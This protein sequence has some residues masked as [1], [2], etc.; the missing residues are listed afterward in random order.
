M[1]RA[2]IGFAFSFAAVVGAALLLRYGSGCGQQCSKGRCC[3][4]SSNELAGTD[5]VC[6]QWT[7]YRC[8]SP[9]SPDVQQRTVTQYCSGFST[10]CNGEVAHTD[11]AQG[12][13]CGSFV[14]TVTEEGAPHYACTCDQACLT[15][16]ET[17]ARP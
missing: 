11:W 6:A 2:R 12:P 13:S 8:A 15:G 5:K 1:T 10:D 3:D 7:Q 16:N 14:C 9:C 4:L 17:C